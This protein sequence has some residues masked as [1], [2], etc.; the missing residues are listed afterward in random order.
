[1][2]KIS[3]F[4][5]E[6]HIRISSAEGPITPETPTT[7]ET[8]NPKTPKPQNLHIGTNLRGT[9]I[10]AVSNSQPPALAP[11]VENEFFGILGGAKSDP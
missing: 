1:M 11:G 4:S 9:W 3:K 6:N 2:V 8:K 10:P 7:P 5:L